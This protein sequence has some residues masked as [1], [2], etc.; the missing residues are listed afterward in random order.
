MSRCV[1]QTR[2]KFT[3]LLGPVY[4]TWHRETSTERIPR[5]ALLAATNWT[6]IQNPAVG[7]R[8]TGLGAGVNAL[9]VHASS[10]GRTF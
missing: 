3:D 10:V 9:V 8:A 6:V 4:L 2:V 5:V 1:I 7:V